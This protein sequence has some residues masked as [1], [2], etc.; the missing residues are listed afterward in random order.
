MT[1]NYCPKCGAE[2]DSD[3]TFCSTCGADIRELTVK[4]PSEPPKTLIT[5]P[6]PQTNNDK[7]GSAPVADQKTSKGSNYGDF[8]ERF[9]ALII[10]AAIL[11][12]IS[13]LLFFNINWYIANLLSFLIAL[14]YFWLLET[15]NKGQTVGKMA[16][17][18]R[19]V[20]EETLEVASIGDYLLNN[21]L[22]SHLIGLIIDFIIGLIV[23]S[24]DPKNKFRIMENA[25]KT[26]VIQTK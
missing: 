2:V 24:G 5:T 13:I 16:M 26:V 4:E 12:I 6:Q 21:L 15:Y 19:T 3:T 9:V 10:D 17:K 22:K 1:L 20:N 11:G 7:S 18:L 23:N 25:S 14:L 8:W